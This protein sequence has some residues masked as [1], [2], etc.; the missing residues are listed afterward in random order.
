MIVARLPIIREGLKGLLSSESDFQVSSLTR[1]ESAELVAKILAGR[2]DVVLLDVDVLESEGWAVLSDLRSVA[3]DIATIVISDASEDRRVAGAFELGAHGYLTRDAT[4]D[5]MASAIR[6]SRDGLFVMHP[7]AFKTLLI[8]Q[9]AD[10]SSSIEGEAESKRPSERVRQDLIE[11]LSTRELDVLRQIVRGMTNKQI[12]AEL[13]ITEHTV[14]FHIR[15]ILSKLGAA[16]R[17]EAV[18]MALQKGLVTL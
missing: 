4:T 6:A 15:A 12:A 3:P 14:K 9:G 10:D 7:L 17:T 13:I 1:F 8:A 5:E 2:P 11:P 16:N 18:T